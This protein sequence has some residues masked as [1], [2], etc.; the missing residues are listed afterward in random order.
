MQDPEIIAFLL[1]LTAS[2]LREEAAAEWLRVR[3]G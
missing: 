2:E 1:A 3:L